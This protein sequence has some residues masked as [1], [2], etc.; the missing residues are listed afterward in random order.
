M[1]IENT[2]EV[3]D[4]LLFSAIH[5]QTIA[6]RSCL[7]FKD[8]SKTFSEVFNNVSEEW[9]MIDRLL[10]SPNRVPAKSHNLRATCKLSCVL[11]N[12]M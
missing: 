1:I 7:S 11:I 5:A 2:N 9:L 3:Y 12:Y 6:F 4:N 8:K 10:F